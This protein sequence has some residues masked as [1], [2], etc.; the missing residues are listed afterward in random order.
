[1]YIDIEKSFNTIHRNISLQRD[2]T[3]YQ[4]R[5][6]LIVISTPDN[7]TSILPIFPPPI[8]TE[9]AKSPPRHPNPRN[10]LVTREEN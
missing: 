4:I 10:E 5:N 9:K 7:Q 8:Q 6:L 2:E 1:M 3:I